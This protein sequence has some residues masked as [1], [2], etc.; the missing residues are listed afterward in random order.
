MVAVSV[1]Q[2]QAYVCVFAIILQWIHDVLNTSSLCFRH[3]GL[4][5]ACSAFAHIAR[6]FLLC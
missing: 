1:I 2:L 6:L 5:T 3:K 4:Q